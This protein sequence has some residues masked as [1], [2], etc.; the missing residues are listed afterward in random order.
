MSSKNNPFGLHTITPYLIVGNAN[1]LIQLLN[2]IFEAEKRGSIL[3]RQ[4]GSVQHA[5]VM[6]G[7]SIIMIAEPVKN[8]SELPYTISTFYTYVEDCD[9][10]YQKALDLGCEPVLAPANYP[11][12][13]RYG[14]IKDFAGNIW[15]VVTHIRT[16]K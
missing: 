13:D 1:L 10:I 5:E 14:G 15:W 4:D 3:Y 11:H 7:D 9:A 16:N 8:M 12:G 2:D 6:V